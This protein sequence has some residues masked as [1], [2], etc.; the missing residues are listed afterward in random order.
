MKGGPNT[1]RIIQAA[2]DVFH[3]GDDGMRKKARCPL[4]WS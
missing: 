2:I 1:A 4:S 3:Y